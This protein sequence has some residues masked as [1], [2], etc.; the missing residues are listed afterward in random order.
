MNIINYRKFIF[1]AISILLL[2]CIM[3]TDV[4][5]QEAQSRINSAVVLNDV[6]HRFDSTASQWADK[7]TSAASWLFWTLSTISMVWTFGQMMLRKADIGELF[8]E[9]IR[10]ILFTGFFWWILISAPAISR[11]I[12]MSFRQLGGETTGLGDELKPAVFSNVGF[13]VL[14]SVVSNFSSWDLSL[15]FAGI[16]FA[17]GVLVCSALIG[18]HIVILVCSGWILAYAGI[19]FLGFGGSK[20]TS[21]IALN[22]YRAVLQVAAQ[23]FSMVLLADIGHKI[24]LQYYNNINHDVVDINELGAMFVTALVTL[25]L[26]NKI[27]LLISGLVSGGSIGNI[28]GTFGGGDAIRAASAAASAGGSIMATGGK[29]MMSGAANT[30][31][32]AKAM[33]AAFK[34]AKSNAEG[35]KMLG[36]GQGKQ[37]TGGT[38]GRAKGLNFAQAA[39]MGGSSTSN[40]PGGTQG[41]GSKTGAARAGRIAAG[42]VK[43]LAKGAMAAGKQAVNT[44]IDKTV[45][46]KIAKAIQNRK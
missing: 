1:A 8:T 4:M 28:G 33:A 41:Q 6:M 22:Y 5:A 13:Q 46:G 31:G 12:I 18:V 32:G 25:V 3:P 38:Q 36:A 40:K 42:T 7:L 19:F 16:I 9:F 27:P 17:V 14:E 39:G 20:W 10:F 37:G 29:M 21:E 45:G 24:L 2:A 43:N 26:V 11:T 15:S 35:N 44:R 23:L 34:G 30:A